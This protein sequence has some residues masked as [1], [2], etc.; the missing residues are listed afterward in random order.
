MASPYSN[1][2][3]YI[4]EMT[5]GERDIQILDLLTRNMFNIACSVIILICAVILILVAKIRWVTRQ[6]TEGILFLGFILLIPASTILP[7]QR[8]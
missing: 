3:A 4:T 5:V 1:F 8:Y 2:A 7:R 6:R